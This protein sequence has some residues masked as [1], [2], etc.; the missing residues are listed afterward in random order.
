MKKLKTYFVT[1]YAEYRLKQLSKI[2]FIARNSYTTSWKETGEKTYGRVNMFEAVTCAMVKVYGPE[3]NLYLRV[4]GLTFTE[5]ENCLY[6]NIMTCRPGQVIGKMGN[7]IDELQKVLSLV[8]CKDVNVKLKETE[9]L[10]GFSRT[11]NY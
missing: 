10:Y 4:N 8:F 7:R 3:W 9:E 5:D 1:K 2:W 6:L 11:E